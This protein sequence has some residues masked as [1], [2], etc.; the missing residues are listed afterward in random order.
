MPWYRRLHWQILLGLLLGG[1]Y[2]VAAARLGWGGFTADWVA[3]FGTIFLN[4]LKLIAVPLVL[5]SLI[6]G[7]ASL[8][9][10]RT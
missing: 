9:D 2:G 5:A 6:T 7:V 10:L 8:A 1:V 3:P 4:A